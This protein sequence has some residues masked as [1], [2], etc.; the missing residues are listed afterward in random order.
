MNQLV[1]GLLAMGAA[2]AIAAGLAWREGNEARDV[3]ALGSVGGLLGLG[4]LAAVVL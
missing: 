3:A 1:I 2:L 4:A